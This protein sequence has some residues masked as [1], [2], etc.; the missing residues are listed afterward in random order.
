MNGRWR[1]VTIAL[2]HPKQVPTQSRWHTAP[3]T[4]SSNGA[5]VMSVHAVPT[6]VSWS[7]V[8]INRDR[9]SS[10]RPGRLHQRPRRFVTADQAVHQSGG[11]DDSVAF[12]DLRLPLY[13]RAEPV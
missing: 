7:S 9:P 10:S 5:W 2:R 11:D 6:G 3:G 13:D 12:D 8:E 4:A 1:S